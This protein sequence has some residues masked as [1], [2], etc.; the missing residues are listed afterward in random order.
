MTLTLL[1]SHVTSWE[2]GAVDGSR[3]DDAG[4]IQAIRAEAELVAIHD[5]ARPLITAEDT[6]RCCLDALHVSPPPPSSTP[7]CSRRA[8]LGSG[9]PAA[10]FL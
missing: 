10:G 5:S 8:R 6:H 7:F 1:Q 4:P 2:A 9:R 3:S